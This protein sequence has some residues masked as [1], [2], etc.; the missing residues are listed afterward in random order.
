MSDGLDCTYENTMAAERSTMRRFMAPSKRLRLNLSV[1]G[2]QGP[3]TPMKAINCDP[4]REDSGK[5]RIMAKDAHKLADDSSRK[6][7]VALSL[8]KFLTMDDAQSTP[9]TR[10]E[11]CCQIALDVPPESHLCSTSTGRL[12]TA[13]VNNAYLA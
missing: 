11:E 12:S 4:N 7:A 13:S 5:N 2:K 9:A 6:L 8:T 1:S 10:F 3:A